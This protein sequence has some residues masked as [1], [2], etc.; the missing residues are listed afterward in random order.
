MKL[1]RNFWLVYP[2]DSSSEPLIIHHKSKNGLIEV[3]PEYRHLCCGSCGKLDVREAL[4]SHVPGDMRLRLK[5]DLASSFEGLELVSDRLGDL[6]RGFPGS[7]IEY[8]SFP[9][10]TGYSIAIPRR[11]IVP[12]EGDPGFVV[13]RRCDECGRFRSAIWDSDKPFLLEPVVTAVFELQNSI[14][15]MPIWVVSDELLRHIKSASPRITGLCVNP[16]DQI[17]MV[18]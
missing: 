15:T 8:F 3:R 14:G 5:R 6:L 7:E 18:E 16:D 13:S 10:P 1:K 17:S 2:A 12:S 9:K 11:A 4:R